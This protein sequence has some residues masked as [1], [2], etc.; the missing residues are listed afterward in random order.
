MKPEGESPG[1]ELPFPDR[2]LCLEGSAG[3][4]VGEE[5]GVLGQQ[6]GL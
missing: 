3:Q 1:A 4:A 5:Q 6:K 2:Q